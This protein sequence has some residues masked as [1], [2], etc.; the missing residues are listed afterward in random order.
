MLLEDWSQK[1]E[2][3]LF[4]Q[5]MSTDISIRTCQKEVPITATCSFQH[6]QFNTRRENWKDR[7]LPSNESRKITE[8]DQ[9]YLQIPMAQ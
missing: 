1:T 7:P 9:Q 6:Q 8:R 5:I 4:H 3:K 2:I